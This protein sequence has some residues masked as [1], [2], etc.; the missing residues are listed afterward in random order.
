MAGQSL[1]QMTASSASAQ[2]P[3]MFDGPAVPVT[4]TSVPHRQRRV[5]VTGLTSY[6]ACAPFIHP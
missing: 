6:M 2:A 5:C 1:P 4:V 3:Q